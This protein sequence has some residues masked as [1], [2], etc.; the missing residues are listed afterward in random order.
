VWNCDELSRRAQALLERAE[1]AVQRG[2]A[3]VLVSRLAQADDVKRRHDAAN[4]LRLETDR[5]NRQLADLGRAQLASVPPR[6]GAEGYDGVGRLT[7]VMPAKLGAPRYAL[8]DDQGKVQTYVSP[9]PG[10]NMQYYLG[11]RVG[12]SGVQ[13]YLAEQNA[14]LLT[15]KH[16]TALDARVR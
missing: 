8:V 14:P 12:V 4:L 9:A 16:V 10:V 15:A 1:T 5:T 13:G 11:R 3:R 2:H 6:S 7:R